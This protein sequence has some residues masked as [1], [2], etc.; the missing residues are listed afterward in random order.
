MLNERLKIDTLSPAR[1]LIVGSSHFS[2]PFFAHVRRGEFVS[3]D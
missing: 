2:W 3:H 1:P